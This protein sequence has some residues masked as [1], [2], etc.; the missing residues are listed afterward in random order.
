MVDYEFLDYKYFLPI[1][2]VF[3]CW[4]STPEYRWDFPKWRFYLLG[5]NEPPGQ[6]VINNIIALKRNDNF[7]RDTH[8]CLIAN[9]A[10][11]LLGF[12]EFCKKL[13]EQYDQGY[14]EFINRFGELERVN[15]K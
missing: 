10:T 7:F 2:W 3:H 4:V 6:I 1:R 5:W 8:S 11:T 12:I 13:Y 15:L 14:V 9:N